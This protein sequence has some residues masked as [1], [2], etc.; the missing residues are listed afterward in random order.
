MT[1]K[2]LALLMLIGLSVLHVVSDGEAT[3]KLIKQWR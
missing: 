2:H 3:I 1:G